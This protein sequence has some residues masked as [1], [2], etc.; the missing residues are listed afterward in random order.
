[1]VRIQAGS[2]CIRNREILE[3]LFRAYRLFLADH[4][5]RRLARWRV[6]CFNV[7]I[8][9]LGP[10]KYDEL[11]T[12]AREDAKADGLVMIVLYGELGSGFSCQATPEIT[13]NLPQLLRTVAKQIEES[14][15]SS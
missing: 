4:Q 1:L 12:K 11:C 3:A 5:T 13:A 15:G 2:D 6:L 14:F 7:C 10:G 8:M 9:S